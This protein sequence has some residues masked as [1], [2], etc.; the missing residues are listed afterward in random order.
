MPVCSELGCPAWVPK[1]GRCTSHRRAQAKAR[2]SRQSR[3]YDAGHDR[4]RRRWAPLVARGGVRCPKCHQ[5]IQPGERWD[6]GHTDDRTTW[7]GPEHA[8]RCNRSAAGR[9]SHRIHQRGPTATVEP[10]DS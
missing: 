1:S 3:G 2:G 7:T 10:D 4:E 9:R 6:L 8:D 5:L